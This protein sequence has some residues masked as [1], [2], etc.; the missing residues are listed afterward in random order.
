MDLWQK[1]NNAAL[2]VMADGRPVGVGRGVVIKRIGSLETKREFLAVELPSGRALHYVNPFLTNNKFDR[3][4][5]HYYDMVQTTHKWSISSTYGGKLV[6]NIVQAIARDCLAETL[7]RLDERYKDDP[8]VMHVHDEVILDANQD[9]SVEEI[10]AVMGEPIPWA[11]GLL[12]K[13]EGF[14][15]EYYRKD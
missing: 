15:C 7:L 2:S 6:E 1:V 13:A 14:E 12:L 8:V 9:V 4:A 10:C 11:P 5:L 3:P